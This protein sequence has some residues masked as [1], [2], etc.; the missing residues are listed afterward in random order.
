MEQ[1]MRPSI[2]SSSFQDINGDLINSFKRWIGQAYNA[3][4]SLAACLT[5]TFG[6]PPVVELGKKTTDLINIFLLTDRNPRVEP[7]GFY[8]NEI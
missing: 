2:A 5:P 8:L 3:S 4:N 1:E 7:V 6:C